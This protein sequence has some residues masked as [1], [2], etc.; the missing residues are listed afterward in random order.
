MRFLVVAT[1]S[2]SV[3]LAQTAG[4]IAGTVTDSS[5]AAV[6]AADV[7]LTL[8]GG[9]KPVLSTQTTT[10]GL[11]HLPGVPA[12]TYDLTVEAPG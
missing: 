2:I 12:G 9:N 8:P 5:G 10:E 7:R 1:L 6:P 11:F 3:I 4:R